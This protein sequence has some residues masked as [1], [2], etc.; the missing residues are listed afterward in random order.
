MTTAREWLDAEDQRAE[1]RIRNIETR[2]D[3][4]YPI[5]RARL[6]DIEQVR[7]TLRVARALERIADVLG[8]DGS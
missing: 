3:F 4:G 6:A 8:G 2:L 1:T 5:D 7:A